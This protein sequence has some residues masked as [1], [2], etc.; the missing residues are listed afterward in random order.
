[1]DV[2]EVEHGGSRDEQGPARDQGRGL[3]DDGQRL[4]RVVV[5]TGEEPAD[6]R[7]LADQRQLLEGIGCPVAVA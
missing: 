6:R 7:A 2:F 5:M 4:R 1:M 3:A